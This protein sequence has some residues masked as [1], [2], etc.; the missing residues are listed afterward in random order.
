[1]S[2]R[3]L[4]ISLELPEE[5]KEILAEKVNEIQNSQKSDWRWEDKT[6]YHLTLKFLGETP[7]NKIPSITDFIKSLEETKKFSFHFDELGI[8]KNKGKPTI[9]WAGIHFENDIFQLVQKIEDKMFIFGYQRENRI[10]H[11][12][13]TL[14]RIKDYY[15][16]WLLNEYVG[17][18]SGTDTFTADRICLYQSI[19]ERSGSKYNKIIE[20]IL[21]N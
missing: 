18:L 14:L 16:H 3:R 4:F 17:K 11:P 12:H 19:L 10:F 2:N 9:F 1:M 13:I 6:K 5:A 8:F 21:S 15:D 7:E 20:T